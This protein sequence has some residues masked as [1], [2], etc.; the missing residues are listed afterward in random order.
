MSLRLVI[1]GDEQRGEAFGGSV[2]VV[3]HVCGADVK[4]KMK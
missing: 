3:L 2:V 4:M 1:V